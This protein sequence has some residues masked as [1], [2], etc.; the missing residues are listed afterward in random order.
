MTTSSARVPARM[1]AVSQ[2]VGGPPDVLKIIEMDRPVPT[3]GEVLV[4]VH[5]AGVNPTDWKTR[6][7]GQFAT[8]AVPPFV[9]GFDV[10]A[11]PAPCGAAVG[12]EN[13]A[14]RPG[15]GRTVTDA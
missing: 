3:V 2:D 14:A 1:L 6:A 12:R 8:G 4:R 15:R 11:S 10:S 9:L 7:R 13:G 5:A